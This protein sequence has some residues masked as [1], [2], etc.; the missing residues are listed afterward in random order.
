MPSCP[1]TDRSLEGD[2]LWE[3]REVTSIAIYRHLTEAKRSGNLRDGVDQLSL[4][5]GSFL[6]PANLEEGG[7]HN[8]RTFLPL[9]AMYPFL[10]LL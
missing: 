9:M 4:V 5:E 7:I 10:L 8:G 2:W 3:V 6:G 1:I